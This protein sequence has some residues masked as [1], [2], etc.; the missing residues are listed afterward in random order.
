MRPMAATT[1]L[2]LASGRCFLGLRARTVARLAQ[3]WA[4][5]THACAASENQED[6]D[7]F[8]AAAGRGEVEAA[9]V[10]FWRVAPLGRRRRVV[11]NTR[12]K[13][14]ANAGRH[15]GAAA[16]FAEMTA[17]RIEPNPQT[18]GKLVEAAAKAGEVE[19]ARGWLKKMGD[20]NI[21]LSGED[22]VV[23]YGAMIDAAAKAFD[24]SAAEMWH[25]QMVKAH[26]RP[27]LKAY[28]SLMDAAA[29]RGDVSATKHW[30]SKMIMAGIEPDE[31]VYVTLINASAQDEDIPAAELWLDRMLVAG[32]APN[33]MTYNTL[34][35]ACA[36]AG[37]LV[38][39]ERWRLRMAAAGLRPNVVTYT[40]LLDAAARRGDDA[41]AAR[42]WALMAADGVQPN[43]LTYNVLLNMSARRADGQGVDRLLGE[44]CEMRLVAT[45]H[46]YNA[47]I[48]A[49]ARAGNLS[50]AE[51]WLERLCA[52]DMAPSAQSFGPIINGYA[53]QSA[54]E[55]ACEKAC[56]WFDEMAR[57]S[58]PPT[59]VQYNQLLKAFAMQGSRRRDDAERAFR[60]M[61]HE[62]MS[63][64]RITL[65]TM[66]SIVGEER[67]AALGA[68]LDVPRMPREASGP[69]S[70]YTAGDIVDARVKRFAR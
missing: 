63:P 39:A 24:L 16:V 66:A 65:A 35:N 42:W 1:V 31:Y 13:A 23:V 37:D 68:A 40:S 28:T 19:V 64:D 50:L 44:M 62:G 8:N 17:A 41:A 36:K 60:Q 52:A 2:R 32:L 47:A 51:R 18:F 21:E 12:L 54:S 25:A 27:D 9:E 53:E 7:L 56:A 29:K 45:R 30:Y 55:A 6:F 67:L 3:P 14:Y 20:H 43:I 33:V 46:S 26:A 4:S 10:L 5:G 38:L 69:S 22:A 15:E 34:I 11:W 57:R 61:V 58:V 48:N 49:H 59:R 70:P